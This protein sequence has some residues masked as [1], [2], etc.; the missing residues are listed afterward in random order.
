MSTSTTVPAA[1]RPAP[2]AT[3]RARGSRPGVL[4]IVALALALGAC[5]SSGS[6]G[7]SGAAAP[8]TAA[9]GAPSGPLLARLATEGSDAAFEQRFGGELDGGGDTAPF[10]MVGRTGDQGVVYVCDGSSGTW[11]TGTVAPDGTGRLRA[12]DGDATVAVTAVDGGLRT[13]F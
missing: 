12:T 7:S 11:F 6:P 5:S 3:A 9:A 4:L 1:R 8:G 2:G 13:A 10:V